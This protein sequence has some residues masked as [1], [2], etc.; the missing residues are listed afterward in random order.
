[1]GSWSPSLYGDD[2][3]ADLKGAVSILCKMP[4]APEVI[5]AALLEMRAAAWSSDEPDTTFWL[6]V[7]DQFERRA[8]ACSRVSREALS[9]IEEGTDLALAQERGADEAYLKKRQQILGELA[10][11]LR[12]PRPARATR[13]AKRLPEMIL[14]TG[15]VFAF[16]A[17][18]GRGLSPHWIDSVYG[19]FEPDGWGALVVLATGRVLDWLPWCVLAALEVSGNERPSLQEALLA[20]LVIYRHFD[21]AEK[22]IPKKADVRTLGL[23]LLGAISLDAARVAAV[24][25]QSSVLT[26]VQR[27]WSVAYAAIG[28]EESSVSDY[29]LSDLVNTVK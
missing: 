13:V 2:D 18:R 17:M 20:R 14:E 1:M 25:A 26:A 27:D 21:G 12:N 4:V 7:A 11:R 16:P 8:I 28:R 10:E 29:V 15:Q 23:E 9:I 24:V 5:V 6:V 3:A 19:R 22:F